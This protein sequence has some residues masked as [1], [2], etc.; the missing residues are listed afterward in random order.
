MLDF[1]EETIDQVSLLVQV[2]IIFPLFSA[3]LAGRDHRFG[4]FLRNLLQEFF[5]IIRAIR[6]YSHEIKICN[7]VFCLGDI[8]S[9][10]ASQQKP[11]RIA[12]GIYASVDLG[13]EPAPAASERLAFL[14][15][16][17]FADPALQGCARTTVLSRKRF[18]ISGSLA[19][20]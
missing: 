7:R 10:S 17:F 8:K 4:F 6:N 16:T 11:Q 2:A 18:S 14:S 15:T 12:Q 19:K 5:R 13:A 1:V 3:F 20:C 9:L